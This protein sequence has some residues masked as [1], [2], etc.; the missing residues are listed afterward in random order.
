MFQ[1]LPLCAIIDNL[2]FCTHGGLS[3][4]LETLNQIKA[5]TRPVCV[6]SRGLICDLLWADPDKDVKKWGINDRGASVTFG[7]E[8]IDAFLQRNDFD[9][10]VRAHQVVANGFELMFD[11]KLVTLFSAPNY[12]NDFQN[13]GAILSINKQHNVAF[14]VIRPRQTPIIVD[15]S[16]CIRRYPAGAT[17]KWVVAVMSGKTKPLEL[18]LGM[19]LAQEKQSTQQSATPP[20][21]ASEKEKHWEG[22]SEAVKRFYMD[23]MDGAQTEDNTE[24]EQQSQQ[25][26]QQQQAESS[27]STSSSSVSSSS[28]SPSSSTTTTAPIDAPSSSIS[29][30]VQPQRQ[31]QQP[32]GIRPNPSLVHQSRSAPRPVSTPSSLTPRRLPNS[33]QKTTPLQHR[34]TQKGFT[35][36]ASPSLPSSFTSSAPSPLKRSPSLSRSEM[37]QGH[38]STSPSAT[39]PLQS[40]RVLCHSPGKPRPEVRRQLHTQT[41]VGSAMA[42]APGQHFQ[43]PA[44]A[45]SSYTF[46]TS[47]SMSRLA[48]LSS[49]NASVVPPYP[50]SSTTSTAFP[51]PSSYYAASSH[52]PQTVS[53]CSFH[54]SASFS[55][56]SQT[57]SSSIFSYSTQNSSFSSFD[58]SIQSRLENLAT[59]RAQPS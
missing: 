50:Y 19:A 45:P 25:Q 51:Y 58:S 35:S 29:T 13:S 55:V 2:I 32:S 9:L 17:N 37:L 6:P 53:Q 47:S 1:C 30:P 27:S 46:N 38:R 31:L 48:A 3:P 40:P 5:I 11:E 15:E 59:E 56:P 10:I 41:A 36:L 12:C 8:A 18:M 21:T 16:S 23:Q 44:S 39:Q 52:T 57:S 24:Q 42:A 34:H 33:L 28:S 26:L 14:S 54:P 7:S 49:S 4:Q 20:P 22:T 43:R